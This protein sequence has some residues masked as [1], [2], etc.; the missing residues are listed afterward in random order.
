M[1]NVNEPNEV[2]NK[3]SFCYGCGQVL[4]NYSLLV[5]SECLNNECDKFASLAQ[6]EPKNK[7]RKIR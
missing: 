3:P 5:C 4:R 1:T 7:Q 2:S 6:V